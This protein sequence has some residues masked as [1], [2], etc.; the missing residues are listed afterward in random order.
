MSE[1]KAVAGLEAALRG[2]KEAEAERDA[3]LGHAREAQERVKVLAK[4][5]AAAERRVK[6]LESELAQRGPVCSEDEEFL[7]QARATAD[8]LNR[9]G[10]VAVRLRVNGRLILQPTLA[11]AAAEARKHST[12]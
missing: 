7:S 4:E 8:W 1:N 3:A 9:P 5:L 12:R 6:R 11:E 10:Y 2:F